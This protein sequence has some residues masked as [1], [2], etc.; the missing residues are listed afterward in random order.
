MLMLTETDVTNRERS[1][2]K[3]LFALADYMDD[4]V[5]L[6]SVCR[7]IVFVIPFIV[8][9]SFSL[10]L[11]TLPVPA[12]QEFLR[13]PAGTTMYLFLNNYYQA[14]ASF[15][16]IIVAASIGWN[17][18]KRWHLSPYQLIFLPLLSV[19]CFLILIDCRSAYLSSRGMPSSI[20]AS[21]LACG[22]YF[23]LLQ[24]FPVPAA[25]KNFSAKPYIRAIAISIFPMAMVVIITV[26]LQQILFYLGH[27]K[28]FQDSLAS[29]VAYALHPLESLTLLVGVIHTLVCQVWWFFGIHGENIMSAIRYEY[30]QSAM[31][32]NVA[33]MQMGRAPTNIINSGFNVTFMLMGG[34]GCILSLIAAI[35]I[36][37][38]MKLTRTLAKIS[39]LPAL[40]NVSEIM[41]FGLPIVCNPIYFIPFITAPVLN[42]IIAYEVTKLGLVPV[43]SNT[44]P[45]TT[46]VLLNAYLA[47]A[48][49]SGV[50]L[51]AAL[52]IIDT[53]LYIPFVRL[54]EEHKKHHLVEHVRELEVLCRKQEE[55][56]LPLRRED[57]NENMRFTVD[58]LIEELNDAINKRENLYL[59]YQPQVNLQGEFI[60]A[61]ALLRW[62]HP[63]AKFIYPPLIISLS[64]M[65]HILP[66]LEKF[67]F[68]ESAQGIAYLE[69]EL[70]KERKFKISINITGES[71]RYDGMEEAL[72]EAVE[73]AA[74]D[75]EKLWVEL[76]E[77]DAVSLDIKTIERLRKLRDMG[78]RLAIDDFGMGHTSIKYLQAHI[79]DVV[80]LDGSITK[81]VLKDGSSNQIVSSL[82]EL[83]RKMNMITIAEYVDN[84]P[85]RDELK[86]LGCDIFQGYL[87]GK[88][89][90]VEELCRLMQSEPRM[91]DKQ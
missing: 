85:Q 4:S 17:F 76:T 15:L 73:K 84:E 9:N 91:E 89:V 86:R 39:L 18:A 51:Q 37:G 26:L 60:G 75:K 5:F 45:W 41:I 61:E 54:D 16:G 33:A 19:V 31:S 22:L 87:Y 34:C 47:T 71:L 20:F 67:I 11:M 30:Y 49:M 14:G 58:V 36:V 23:K 7:G 40:T 79:F 6:Q 43:I 90:P 46:P 65:G 63:L 81:L 1:W 80:K 59:L 57:L 38:R 25:L 8:L 74:I 78:H 69:R 55:I 2:K 32:A 21:V 27:G 12:Y 50:Y 28:I 52:L 42:M 88:P 70:G 83:S 68:N 35:L 48:S 56:H 62:D 66:K 77:Q 64:K 53:M 72:S 10:L 82:A 29:M 44:V 3:R 24:I 13:T